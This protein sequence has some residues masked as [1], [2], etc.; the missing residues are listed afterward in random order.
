M[1]NVKS[2][3]FMDDIVVLAPTRRWLRKAVKSFNVVLATVSLEKHPEK[4]FIGRVEKG[5]DFLGYRFSPVGRR[6]ARKTVE[7]FVARAIRLYE[8]EPGEPC[9]SARWRPVA[10]SIRIKWSALGAALT[11]RFSFEFE[12]WRPHS[13]LVLL[14][15]GSAAAPTRRSTMARRKLSLLLPRLPVPT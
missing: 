5:F 13:L 2:A 8:Q 3:R 12:E 7:N 6:I 15:L 4:T 9:D 1:L 11:V 10:L 14:G